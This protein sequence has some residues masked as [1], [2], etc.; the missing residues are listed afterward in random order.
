MHNVVKR[1][2]SYVPLMIDVI[3]HSLESMKN[4]DGS[5]RDTADRLQLLDEQLKVLETTA[6]GMEGGLRNTSKVCINRASFPS[7]I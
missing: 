4:R 2:S 7:Q 6:K 5:W 1:L 3:Y